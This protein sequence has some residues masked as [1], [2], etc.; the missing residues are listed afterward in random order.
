MFTGI[1][2]K[3]GRVLEIEKSPSQLR[4][5]L[6]SGFQNVAI[7][8][9]IAVNGVCLTVTE[10]KPAGQLFF[11]VSQ[12]TLD[13][14][15]LGEIKIGTD[16]NLERA[17]LASERLS[18]HIVQGHVDSQ[19]VFLGAKSVGESFEVRFQLPDHLAHYVVEKGSI[20]LNGVSL[21]INHVIGHESGSADRE[22]SIM[23]IPHTWENT[24]LSR[25]QPGQS[26]NVEIDILAKYM[27]K[28]CQ[29]YVKR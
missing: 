26:V 21:T 25:L 6:D 1:I 14:S 16:V 3:V 4:V 18:G 12:E 20:C 22:I 7:G 27:E 24:N 29:P 2:Q 9:S 28:L 11:Y 17:L 19:A 23:L 13:R 15:N 5:C 8:E 10:F